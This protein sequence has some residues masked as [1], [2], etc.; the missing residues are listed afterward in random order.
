MTVDLSG[1]NVFVALAQEIDSA[2]RPQRLQAHLSH[3]HRRP[4]AL[5]QPLRL[6]CPV[7]KHDRESTPVRATLSATPRAAHSVT[8]SSKCLIFLV[9]AAGLEPATR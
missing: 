7:I 8:H 9:G 6:L 3:L 1:S 5:R 4:R 2:Q